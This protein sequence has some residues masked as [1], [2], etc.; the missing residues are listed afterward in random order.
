MNVIFLIRLNP[1]RFLAWEMSE[2]LRLIKFSLKMQIEFELRVRKNSNPKHYQKTFPL[3]R[4]RFL[5]IAHLNSVLVERH[6]THSSYYVFFLFRHSAPT[7][8]RKRYF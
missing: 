7:I 2:P 5:Q 1:F 4:S 8:D 6:F 3:P